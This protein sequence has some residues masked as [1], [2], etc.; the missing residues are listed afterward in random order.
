[1]CSDL[2]RLWAHD[3]DD[4][5]DDPYVPP[6]SANL[7]LSPPGG[8][9]IARRTRAHADL[10]TVDLDE[11]TREY[12]DILDRADQ[13]GVGRRPLSRPPSPPAEDGSELYAEGMGGQGEGGEGGELL[14]FAALL[15]IELPDDD[16]DE[17]YAPNPL[18]EDEEE[19]YRDDY[20]TKVSSQPINHSPICTRPHAALSH[21][22]VAVLCIFDASRRS[23]GVEAAEAG[24]SDG[25][26]VCMQGS[27]VRRPLVTSASALAVDSCPTLSHVSFAEAAEDEPVSTS[28]KKKGPRPRVGG[29]DD[30]AL[31]HDVTPY[32]HPSDQSP[33]PASFFSPSAFSTSPQRSLELDHG[34]DPVPVSL[35]TAPV[36]LMSDGSLRA[37]DGA[38]PAASAVSSSS[39][40][41]VAIAASVIA[42]TGAASELCTS[43]DL[44]SGDALQRLRYQLNDHV[45]LLIQSRLLAQWWPQQNEDLQ[46]IQQNSTL[47]MED[48]VA[49]LHT[50]RTENRHS[51][52]AVPMITLSVPPPRSL[53]TF[54]S[55]LHL[56]SCL[57]LSLCRW[58][59]VDGAAVSRGCQWAAAVPCRGPGL[60]RGAAPYRGRRSAARRPVHHG[61]AALESSRATSTV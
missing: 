6:R 19:E 33:L 26:S 36:Y 42:T 8:E 38:A 35:V 32:L 30:F 10:R 23:G 59:Q 31:S 29:A 40:H 48:I 18:D 60:G 54:E 21:S 56:V 24:V 1:M 3:L 50:A 17:E 13:I 25:G 11:W 7:G 16:N 61:R 20:T 44:W 39:G 49:Q 45:Q 34:T 47:M 9:A 5:D 51:T 43:S 55:L 2:G 14:P 15:D 58:L 57:A 41:R 22:H 28:R 4:D 12:E 52:A 27:P 37:A 53:T 46:R